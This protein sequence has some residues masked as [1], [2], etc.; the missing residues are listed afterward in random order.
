[1]PFVPEGSD[2][3]QAV[4]MIPAKV[5]WG[6]ESVGDTFGNR[7]R[8]PYFSTRDLLTMAALAGLG[9]VVSTHV[10]ALGDVFQSV[11]GF[12]GT[13]Q[14]A[15]GLHV[16]WL[17]LAV[18]LTG[19]QGSGTITGV[20]KGGVELLSGNTHGL[21][22]VLVDVVAGLLVDLGFLPFR[23]KGSWPAYCLAGGLASVSNVFVFQLFASLP[24]DVLAYG[25]LFIVGA[26]A[27]ASG[28]IFA[29][30]LGH[31]LFNTLRRAGV[32]RDRPTV[33]MRRPLYAV[34]LL[35]AVVLTVGLTIYL[36]QALRGPTVVHVGGSVQTP[37]DYPV[38]N[39]DLP[40][41]TAEGALRGVTSRYSGVPLRELIDRAG[42]DPNAS[43]VIVEASDGYAFF[44]DMAEVRENEGLLLA[45][46]G[47]GSDASYDIVGASNSKAWVRGVAEISMV[48]S[49]T[50]EFSGALERP[51]PFDPN[52]WQFDM[53][54]AR[55]DLGDGPRKYQGAAL[56]PVL[57]EMAPYSEA[58]TVIFHPPADTA[59]AAELSLPLDQVLAD[60]DIR[61]FTRIDDDG[62]SFAVA[63]MD[64]QVIAAEVER[65]EVR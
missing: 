33:S 8:G 63:R 7:R 26:V 62:V 48:P 28:V 56:G 58:T 14:W 10:N 55:L 20:L 52:D 4:W 38:E 57:Q 3:G 1:M 25:G 40:L 41:I 21:L 44:L 29:G 13:T 6:M 36:R 17:V 49:A 32:V 19:K 47:S 24:A 54:S 45:P 22:V 43:L 46:Q 59:S 23:N 5:F 51:A 18:G 27:F 34:F 35:V 12:A 53:D 42:A 11:L 60:Q 37:Y 30:L 9:G 15:A 2:A 61:I 50:L 65:I 39:G 31:V 16:L 64:G